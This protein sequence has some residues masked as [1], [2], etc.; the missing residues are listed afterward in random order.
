MENKRIYHIIGAGLAG[1]YTAKLLK[2]YNPAA[3]VIVY[4]S[5]EKIGGRCQSFFTS[6]FGCQVDNATHVLLNCNSLAQSLIGKECFQHIIR[7]YDIHHTKF[8]PILRAL[9]DVHLAVFNSPHTSY[10]Q[11]FYLYCQLFPFWGLKAYFS[12][13]DLESRLCRPLLQYCDEIRY[14]WIWKD[15]RLSDTF[16][17]QLIFNKGSVNILPN[18]IIIS[19]IDSY[20]YHKIIGG[21][22][23]E[24]SSICNLFYR[25]SMPLTLPHNC[26]MLSIHGG[27]SQWLF[28]TSQYSSVTISNSGTAN[29]HPRDIWQEICTIRDYNS[30]FLPTYQIRNFPRATICQ[31][32]RNNAKRPVSATTS[33]QNL[34]ICGDWT[35]KNRPCCIE[36]ALQSARRVCN[37]IK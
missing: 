26:R 8:I 36:T 16:V 27:K 25:T 12:G 33:F 29:I 1:L 30:A 10:R 4:E 7:F 37:T 14:G 28:S 13:G 2:E 19:A 35:M 34:F 32:E 18:D 20:N 3:Y 22:D 11:K 17:Y 6:E 23:F 15:I 5:A 24:Y 21:F 9:D 31:D